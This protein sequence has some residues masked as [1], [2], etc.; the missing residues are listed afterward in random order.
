MKR[1]LTLLSAIAVSAVAINAQILRT[2]CEQGEIEGELHNGYALYKAILMPRSPS[3]TC[4]GMRLSG[5]PHGKV[6]IKLKTGA[7][8]RCRSQIPIKAAMLCL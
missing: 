3:A 1:L 7:T 2:V 5:K 4:A 6:S 8:V